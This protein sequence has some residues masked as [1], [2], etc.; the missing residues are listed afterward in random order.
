MH[1]LPV[2]VFMRVEVERIGDPLYGDVRRLAALAGAEVALLPVEL[3]YGEDGAYRL[4]AALVGVNTGRVAWL[5]VIQGSKGVPED[6]STLAS[7]ADALALA[8]VPVG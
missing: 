8:I 6:P 7:V 5:G 4:T 2:D 1:D 3:R